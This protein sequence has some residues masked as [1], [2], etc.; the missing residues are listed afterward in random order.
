M[1]ENEDGNHVFLVVNIVIRSMVTPTI[2]YIILIFIILIINIKIKIKIESTSLSCSVV[3]LYW[4]AVVAVFVAF[5][6]V[7]A[8]VAI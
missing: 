5:T 2:L 6:V 8:G 7:I 4:V 1:A 3:P